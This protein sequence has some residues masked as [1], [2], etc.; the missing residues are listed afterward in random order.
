MNRRSVPR[1]EYPYGG[2]RWEYRR[3][4]ALIE[5][6]HYTASQRERGFKEAMPHHIGYGIL[7]VLQ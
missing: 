5:G 7:T 4:N 3:N 2:F 1:P 6:L